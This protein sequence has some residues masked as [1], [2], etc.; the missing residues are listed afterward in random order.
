MCEGEHSFS[1]GKVI[2]IPY[3]DEKTAERLSNGGTATTAGQLGF[4]LGSMIQQFVQNRIEMMGELRYQIIAE[5]QGT[6]DTL[7]KD[8]HDKVGAPYERMV[9]EK[10][11]V[12]H[13]DFSPEEGFI[14]NSIPE[15]GK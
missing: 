7:S 10:N 14:V 4:Q 9:E 2:E 11:D 15:E 8:F 1:Q 3:V 6:L 13:W 5:V 12:F